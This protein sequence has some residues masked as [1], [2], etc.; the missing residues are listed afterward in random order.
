MHSIVLPGGCPYSFESGFVREEIICYCVENMLEAAT[1]AFYLFIFVR[2]QVVPVHL[3]LY[4][5][6]T[7]AVDIFVD[8]NKKIVA[9]D[10]LITRPRIERGPSAY[11]IRFFQLKADALPRAT[12]WLLLLV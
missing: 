3:L 5:L 4:L 6:Q 1:Q 7:Q 10:G 2:G 12:G 8:M 9:Y 11:H